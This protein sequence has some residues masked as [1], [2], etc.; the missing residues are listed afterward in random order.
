V[1]ALG[2]GITKDDLVIHDEKAEEPTLAYLLSRM[3]HFPDDPESYPEPVGVFRAVERPTFT[4]MV[5]GQVE[6][7]IKAKG[8]GNLLGSAHR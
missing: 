7:V 2:S 5:N 1:V 3:V 8:P 4:E 6:E